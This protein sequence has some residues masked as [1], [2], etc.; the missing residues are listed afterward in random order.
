MLFGEETAVELEQR[1]KPDS[2]TKGGDLSSEVLEAARSQPAASG[3][4][5]LAAPLTTSPG[6]Y[7]RNV[8]RHGA[9]GGQH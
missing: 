4:K 2:Y 8:G 6:L 7:W 1:Y 5:S 3:W 9:R